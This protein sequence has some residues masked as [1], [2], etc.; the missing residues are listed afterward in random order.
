MGPLHH[1]AETSRRFQSRVLSQAWGMIALRIP[2]PVHRGSVK[3]L[4]GLPVLPLPHPT[5]LSVVH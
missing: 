2:S 3:S 5:L 1:G 4:L